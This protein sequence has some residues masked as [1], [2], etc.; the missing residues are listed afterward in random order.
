MNRQI[1]L[2]KLFE[3]F[4]VGKFTLIRMFKQYTGMLPVAYM[5]QIRH[6]YARPLLLAS[7]MPIAEIAECCGY[8]SVSFFVSDF[9]NH[10]GI[11]PGQVRTRNEIN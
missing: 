9:K 8:S 7:D 4:G 6:K 1:T 3:N 11:T 10:Q 5:I 2:E